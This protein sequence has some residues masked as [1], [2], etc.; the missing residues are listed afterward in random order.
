MYS[1]PGPGDAFVALFKFLCL[2]VIVFVPLG[3]WKLFEILS[4]F[5]HHIHW[6]A[7]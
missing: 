7:P 1:V 6:S 4:W 5:F 3:I 2:L